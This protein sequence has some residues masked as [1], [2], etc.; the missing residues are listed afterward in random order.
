MASNKKNA[1]LW[2]AAG[3]LL[4]IMVLVLVFGGLKGGILVADEENIPVTADVIL[5]SVQDGDWVSLSALVSG[6]PDLEPQLPEEGTAERLIWNAYQE[7]LQWELEEGYTVDGSRIT[8]NVTVT[9]LDI[10][11]VSRVLQEMSMER[12]EAFVDAVQQ[13][14]STEANTMQQTI[15]LT[16]VRESGVWVIIPNN[17]LLALMSGFTAP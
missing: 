6:H 15:T 4:S 11:S 10:A 9:C 17:A 12:S 13:L 14:L 16:M 1:F 2:A 5:R 8:Q 3:L 7:S